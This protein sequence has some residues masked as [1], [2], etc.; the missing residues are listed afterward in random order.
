MLA[1][2]FLIGSVVGGCI[3]YALVFF[4]AGMDAEK[5]RRA[6]RQTLIVARPKSHPGVVG[7]GNHHHTG[8]FIRP[9]RKDRETISA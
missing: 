9:S 7:H 2:A 1:N 6:H 8:P 5:R 4:F 3:A